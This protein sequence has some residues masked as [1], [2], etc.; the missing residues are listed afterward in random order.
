MDPQLVATHK[1]YLKASYKVLNKAKF[2]NSYT[3]YVTA[4]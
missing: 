3:K 2:H 4:I 1:A